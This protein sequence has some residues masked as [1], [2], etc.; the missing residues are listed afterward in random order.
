MF[1]QV[2]L[3][4]SFLD[5]FAHGRNFYIFQAYFHNQIVVVF[6]YV[7]MFPIHLSNKDD[8]AP[9]VC[10]AVFK[11]VGAY[12]SESKTLHFMVFTNYLGETDNDQL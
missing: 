4:I 12:I 1:Y 11:E 9:A 8:W 10:Q 6:F 3:L 5:I 7:S 2:Q